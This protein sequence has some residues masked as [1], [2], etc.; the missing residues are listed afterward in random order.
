MANQQATFESSL[1]RCDTMATDD[2]SDQSMQDVQPPSSAKSSS[3]T[4]PKASESVL[5]STRSRHGTST[6]TTGR[7][8][9]VPDSV[10][11]NACTTCK[12]ARAKVRRLIAPAISPNGI[13]LTFQFS[14]M[15]PNQHANDVSVEMC[16]TLASTK[17]TAKRQKSK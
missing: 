11:P 12:K 14:A 9:K 13:S 7:K 2:S 8:R 3:S 10:T 1:K 6:S 4:T 5:S 15:V 17:S 16:A